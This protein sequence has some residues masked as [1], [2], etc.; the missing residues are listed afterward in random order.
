MSYYKYQWGEPSTPEL[1]KL[2]DE[3]QE[4]WQDLDQEIGPLEYAFTSLENREFIEARGSIITQLKDLRKGLKALI[5]K[6][7]ETDV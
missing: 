1:N 5:K 4:C 6:L 3:F 7:E 2:R